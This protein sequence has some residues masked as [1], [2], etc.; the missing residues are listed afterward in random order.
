MTDDRL[1]DAAALVLRT[2]MGLMFF[3]HGALL[4]YATY[5]L[6]GTAAYFASIGYPAFMGYLVIFAETIGGLLMMAGY[7]VRLIAGLM[8]PIMI[9]ATLE[10]VGNGWVFSAAGGGYEFPAFWT[11]AL[12][13]QILLGAGMWS[14]DRYL[15]PAN[16]RDRQRS[17]VRQA[18]EFGF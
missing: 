18:T 3:A 15:A 12:V 5:G 2:T 10:H 9:G 7:K 4:K 1:H 11:V 17:R 14:V 16:L 8:L 6:N 13:V